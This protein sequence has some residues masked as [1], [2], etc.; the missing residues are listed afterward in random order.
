MKSYQQVSF[1]LLQYLVEQ[2]YDQGQL[3]QANDI[4]DVL[5]DIQITLLREEE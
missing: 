5:D 3:E 1:Q 2:S 4:G